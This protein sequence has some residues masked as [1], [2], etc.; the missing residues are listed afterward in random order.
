VLREPAPAGVVSKD[1]L[2]LPRLRSSVSPDFLRSIDN[3]CNLQLLRRPVPHFFARS[4]L[5]YANPVAN[6]QTSGASPDARY[7][8]PQV[9]CGGS[10]Y[11]HCSSSYVPARRS[12]F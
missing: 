11:V 12:H 8:D 4:H 7:F 6:T 10:G 3:L 5:K 9:L 2:L 1:L